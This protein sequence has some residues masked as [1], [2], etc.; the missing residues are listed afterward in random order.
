MEE[1][2]PLVLLL[3]AP[4]RGLLL[5]QLRRRGEQF[6]CICRQTTKAAKLLKGIPSLCFRKQK[7]LP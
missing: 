5:A 3:P 6:L 4:L 7:E 2:L 1:L